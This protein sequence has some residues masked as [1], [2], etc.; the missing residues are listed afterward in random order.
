P[1]C[2]I[3][4][5]I[6]TSKSASMKKVMVVLSGFTNDTV[7]TGNDGKYSF[8]KVVIGKNYTI[9]PYYSTF[10]LEGVST[11]DL[12]VINKSILGQQAIPSEYKKVAADV[13][14][15]GTISTADMNILNKMILGL[16]YEFPSKKTWV[17][18][19]PG[20]KWPN[21]AGSAGSLHFNNIQVDQFNANFVG[22]KLGDVTGTN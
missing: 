20:Y 15:S 7:F 18:V 1:V 2:S 8:D 16:Q 5:K 4:G 22:V 21:Q 19:T 3:S 10:A 11:G 13:N 14:L 12:V 9:T 17:F 6:E